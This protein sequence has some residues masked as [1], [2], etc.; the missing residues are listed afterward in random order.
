MNSNENF[1]KLNKLD[2][3]NNYLMGEI[4]FCSNPVYKS[5]ITIILSL[6]IIYFIWF[7]SRKQYLENYPDIIETTTPFG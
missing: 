1:D 3:D 4:N 7:L 6:I 2:F 5:I